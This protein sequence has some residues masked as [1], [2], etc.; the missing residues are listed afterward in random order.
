MNA[1]QRTKPSPAQAPGYRA[2]AMHSKTTEGTKHVAIADPT[3]SPGLSKGET[4]APVGSSPSS[5]THCMAL[6][7]APPNLSES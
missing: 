2:V 6:G 7:Q 5:A 4:G 3:I 1:A